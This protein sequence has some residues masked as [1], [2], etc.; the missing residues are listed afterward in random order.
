MFW[1]KRDGFTQPFRRSEQDATYFDDA[2]SFSAKVAELAQLIGHSSFTVA[3]TGAGFSEDSLQE[4]AYASAAASTVPRSASVRGCRTIPTFAHRALAQLG[5]RRIVHSTITTSSDGLQR[6]A[7]FPAEALLELHGSVF[8]E[9]C[10]SCGK[11]FRRTSKVETIAYLLSSL[12]TTM[13]KGD[14][15]VRNFR[16]HRLS[17]QTKPSKIAGLQMTHK[18]LRKCNYCACELRDEIVGDGEVT[19]AK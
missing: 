18:T 2:R 13:N 8:A 11:T 12:L 17:K 16:K 3:V 15:D 5:V 19:N 10:S 14:F 7:G 9:V 4:H 1:E 6:K